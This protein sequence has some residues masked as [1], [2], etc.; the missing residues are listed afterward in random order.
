M[1]D[2]NRERWDAV[3]AASAQ[4]WRGELGR[5]LVNLTTWGRAPGR[6][7][8]RLA[9]KGFT[10]HYSLDVTAEE[11]VD[12]WDYDLCCQRFVADGFPSVWPNFG[13]GVA[14][15]FLGCDLGSDA[16]TV[17][18]HPREARPVQEVAFQFDPHNRWLNRVRDIV[19]TAAARWRGAVQVGMTDLGGN[20]DIAASFRP[21]EGLLLDLYDAP[22]EII[23]LAWQAHAQW[24]LFFD[25]LDRLQRLVNPGYTCWTAIFSEQPYY[26]LQCDFAYMLGPDMFN[27][28]V[29]PELRATC[30]RLPHGFYHLDGIGQLPHLDALLAIPELKGIQ[31]VPGDG[32][33]DIT[34]WPEI[35]R[36]IRK[37]G[38][39]I[40][41]FSGQ[42]KL[43]VRVLDVLAEQLGSADG[44]VLIG[45]FDPRE[46]T[47]VQECLRRHCVPY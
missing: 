10:A 39:L 40:Q 44:I 11:I 45:G 31:W 1:I 18:F 3:R 4:W 6:A 37:A 36:R 35:Y 20:L 27:A 43:G 14:A 8:P 30:R 9:G 17:W 32:Q 2:F 19:R 42:S 5:P 38:K 46:Q 34:H 47:A 16:N 24:W 33:P 26:M 41:C 12:R 29:L 15:A 13:P 7:E 22:E 25:D 21:G 23:R 28:F